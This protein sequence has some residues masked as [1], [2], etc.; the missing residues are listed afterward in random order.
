MKDLL[1]HRLESGTIPGVLADSDIGICED[2]AIHAEGSVTTLVQSGEIDLRKLDMVQL[3]LF[4]DALEGTTYFANEEDA[5][6]SGE[7]TKAK[8]RT[9]HKA[10]DR[11]EEAFKSETGRTL[12]IPRQ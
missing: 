9:A 6:A 7:T 11:L 12:E 2:D 10:A 1:N 5:I 8:M 3:A 4:R